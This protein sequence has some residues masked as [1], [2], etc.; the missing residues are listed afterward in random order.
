MF[1]NSSIPALRCTCQALYLII[2]D[3]WPALHEGFFQMVYDTLSEKPHPVKCVLEH[4]DPVFSN[5]L[6]NIMYKAPRILDAFGDPAGKH[7]QRILAMSEAF[8]PAI[9]CRVYRVLRLISIPYLI[10]LIQNELAD[11]DIGIPVKEDA[12]GIPTIT[13]FA[14]Y[15]NERFKK[16]GSDWV[17][18]LQNQVISMKV[19][20]QAEAA[21]RV[22]RFSG[23][24]MMF[25]APDTPPWNM[26]A[27]DD[28]KTMDDVANLDEY[29]ED[30]YNQLKSHREE[31]AV[32]VARCRLA[33][34]Q[35]FRFW[36]ASTL[37]DEYCHAYLAV[38]EHANEFEP[39]L[40]EYTFK[41]SC[42]QNSVYK[43]YGTMTLPL[44]TMRGKKEM[45]LF[46]RNSKCITLNITTEMLRDVI[47]NMHETPGFEEDTGLTS[48]SLPEKEG[49]DDWNLQC[50]CEILLF[51]S[52]YE[53]CLIPV[54]ERV[55]KLP[56]LL[57][58]EMFYN[59]HLIFDVVMKAIA[60][61]SARNG[62]CNGRV[63]DFLQVLDG[64]S[65]EAFT[66][67]WH[68]SPF[69][70]DW[71]CQTDIQ[72]HQVFVDDDIRFQA[73]HNR[74]GFSP[75]VCLNFEKLLLGSTDV[76]PW[77]S[78]F[79]NDGYKLECFLLDYN[80]FASDLK[81]V[82]SN[83]KFTGKRHNFNIYNKKVQ[84]KMELSFFH[85][86]KQMRHKFEEEKGDIVT[87]QF[88]EFYKQW[89]NYGKVMVARKIISKDQ[90]NFFAKAKLLASAC[91]TT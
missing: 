28:S 55:T 66:D 37:G 90:L 74:C 64:E 49:I 18:R 67:S 43:V 82:T 56:A 7:Q 77:K 38:K 72:N 62:S 10:A 85:L 78:R 4:L 83:M 19:C 54:E 26:F 80:F 48:S 5:P 42:K 34:F 68:M 27:M 41:S 13:G 16:P 50:V 73:C 30:T 14:N 3:H 23:V 65:L 44:R 32:Y 47:S 89:F 22:A 31:D 51:G 58:M 40:T 25:F 15:L 20:K 45:G 60:T 61:P 9:H 24:I 39:L 17:F 35:T 36:D 52:Y 76:A 12:S 81:A 70:D 86:T 33:N 57:S 75:P 8:L 79:H 69:H 53:F 46:K 88:K 2:L 11:T 71:G 63:T 29:L 87:E 6:G 59:F 91:S 1:G 84:K 21:G